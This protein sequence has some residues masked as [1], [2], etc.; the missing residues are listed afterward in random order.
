MRALVT[1]G[2]GF[3]GRH[4]VKALR[5]RGIGVAVLTRNA[6]ASVLPELKGA[7]IFIGD[8]TNKKSLCN[9]PTQVDYVFH[10][11]VIRHSFYKERIYKTN[12]EGTKN[13]LEFLSE[14][15]VKLKK[16]TYIGSLQASG[17]SN[18]LTLEQE[19]GPENPVSYYNQTKLIAEKLLMNFRPRLPYI[20]LRAP[21]VYGPGQRR[22]Q[23]YYNF[24]KLGIM[25][26][27]DLGSRFIS[28]CYISDFV[29]AMLKATESSMIAGR[30]C[31]SD[32]NIYS[33]KEFFDAMFIATDRKLKLI[34]IPRYMLDF[35]YLIQRLIFPSFLREY[36][37]HNWTCDASRFF[38]DFSYVPC[39]T[40]L[41]GMRKTIGQ[42]AG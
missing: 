36:F 10:L 24:L 17:F 31:V 21:L 20:I 8:L 3:I 18:K 19:G 13:L 14:H 23:L 16:F 1:G 2:T 38:N 22:Y 40:L 9:I 15:N 39:V 26:D 37:Y 4:L 12:I 30:Y 42:N 6:K 41:E 25:P 32:G 33:M 34:S 7:D 29:N 5:E 27:I 35:L 28:I 11:A